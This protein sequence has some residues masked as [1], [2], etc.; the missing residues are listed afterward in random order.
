MSNVTYVKGEELTALANG[1]KSKGENKKYLLKTT[2]GHM[3]P[4]LR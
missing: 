1:L 2:H 4:L 3:N